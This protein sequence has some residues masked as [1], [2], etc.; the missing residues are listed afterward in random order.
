MLEM[1]CLIK[2][3]QRNDIAFLQFLHLYF[4][5]HTKV[6]VTKKK[7]ISRTIDY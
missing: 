1:Q 7:A 5:N 3:I 4:P 6:G 2:L